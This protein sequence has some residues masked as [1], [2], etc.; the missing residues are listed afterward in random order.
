MLSLKS[1]IKFN[2]FNYPAIGRVGL[3]PFLYVHGGLVLTRNLKE[4]AFMMGSSG[5]GVSY[6]IAKSINLELLYPFSQHQNRKY[7]QPST[8]Q[9]RISI[10]D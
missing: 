5:M 3:V 10:N 9:F 1:S 2:V 6:M 8:L 4:D 7:R